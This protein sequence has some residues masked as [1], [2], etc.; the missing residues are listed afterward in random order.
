[1]IFHLVQHLTDV[2][3]GV[4]PEQRALYQVTRAYLGRVA[5][6]GD[7]L[8]RDVPVGDNAVQP[9]VGAADRQRADAEIAHPLS[10]GRDAVVLADA[11][12][13][14]VHDV[15]GLPGGIR[16]AHRPLVR[17]HP[18]VRGH[19][20]EPLVHGLACAC[21]GVLGVVGLAELL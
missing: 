19:S 11:L 13:S 6:L 4:D 10:G 8:H 17:H 16:A 21:P 9:I 18:L 3:V 14:R 5:A 15:S 1:V 12:G 2:G 20:G 7:A